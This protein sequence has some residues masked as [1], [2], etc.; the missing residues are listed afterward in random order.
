MASLV[1]GA[2]E[3]IRHKGRAQHRG[4]RV[5]FAMA[6]AMCAM[7]EHSISGCGR[8]CTREPRS[9]TQNDVCALSARYLPAAL[10]RC[11]SRERERNLGR[12]WGEITAWDGGMLDMLVG[13]ALCIALWGCNGA[14]RRRSFFLP[15]SCPRRSRYVCKSNTFPLRSHFPL[16]TTHPRCIEFRNTRLVTTHDRRSCTFCY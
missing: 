10:R 16:G 8:T 13:I 5:R 12:Q 6:K 11:G 7:H 15:L 1:E 9:E 14:G 2:L 4:E 3:K